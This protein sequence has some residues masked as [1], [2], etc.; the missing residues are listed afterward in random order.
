MNPIDFLKRNR[1]G[2]KIG[3]LVGGIVLFLPVITSSLGLFGES[4]DGILKIIFLIFRFLPRLILDPFFPP[5]LD[6]SSLGAAILE[7]I[8]VYILIF[9]EFIF[10]GAYLQSK[11]ILIK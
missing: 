1:R 4:I 10:L 2:V 8:F 11:R 9:L 5:K 6:L 3:A 7:S